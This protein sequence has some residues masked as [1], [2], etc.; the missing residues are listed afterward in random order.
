M[1]EG[2][3]TLRHA[4]GM[5]FHLGHCA[6]LVVVTAL[7]NTHDIDGSQCTANAYMLQRTQGG[8]SSGDEFAGAESGG[9]H[10]SDEDFIDTSDASDDP[11]E[12]DEPQR[13][14]AR[15]M[16]RAQRSLDMDEG[17]GGGLRRSTRRR[18]GRE[19]GDWEEGFS[20]EG[21]GGTLGGG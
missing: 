17:E 20:E 12:P 7:A 16:R 8:Q 18:L 6:G 15:A 21:G 19:S 13:R 4:T 10:S 5:E 9:D 3:A 1:V 2:A 11:L 14:S